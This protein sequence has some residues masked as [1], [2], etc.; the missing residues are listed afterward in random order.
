MSLGPDHR[1][2]SST[3]TVP[4]DAFAGSTRIRVA[5]RYYADGP[6]ETV[7][8]FDFGEVEDCTG[9]GTEVVTESTGHRDARRLGWAWR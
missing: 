6:P 4:A 2:V 3:F 1:A 9:V 5:M 7:G 8:V